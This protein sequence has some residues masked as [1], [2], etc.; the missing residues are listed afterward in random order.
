MSPAAR[1]APRQFINCGN[2]AETCEFPSKLEEQIRFPAQ[3][4][5][6]NWGGCW[7]ISKRGGRRSLARRE[8]VGLSVSPMCWE[9]S[10]PPAPQ[11]LGRRRQRAVTLTLLSPAMVLT[12]RG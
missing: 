1:I 8:G 9:T 3:W 7:R 11:G 2:W 12:P 10:V 4:A 5:V 6:M